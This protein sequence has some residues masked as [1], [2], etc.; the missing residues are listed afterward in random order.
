MTDPVEDWISQDINISETAV[1]RFVYM[2]LLNAIKQGV[3]RIHFE[4]FPEAPGED[5]D[6]TISYEKDGICTEIEEPPWE[7][8]QNVISRL[9]VMARMVDY[10]PNKSVD[11]H[12]VVQL[13]KN[14]SVDFLMTTNPNPYSDNKVTLVYE[15][16]IQT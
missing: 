10:G 9:K 13:S 16:D 5:G 11:G 3:E 4:R 7:V 12:I 15:A 14:R 2:I 1:A 8:W 6:F